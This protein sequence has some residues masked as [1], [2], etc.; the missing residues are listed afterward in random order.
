MIKQTSQSGFSLFSLILTIGVIAVLA[1]SVLVVVNPAKRI[2]QS[3]DARRWADVTAIAKAVEA[4]EIDNHQIPSDFSTTT[5]SAGEKFV[6]CSSSGFRTCDGQTEICLVVDD[7]DFLGVYLPDIPIDP[8]KSNS[9]DSGYYIT[10]QGDSTMVFGA[11]DSYDS[12]E[13]TLVAKATL[14]D[15]IAVCGDG[16]VDGDEV[17]DDGDT[18]TE[19]CGDGVLDTAGET[20]CNADCS[21]TYYSIE[22]CEFYNWTNDCEIIK[23]GW[24]TE[25][26][27]PPEASWCSSICRT[28]T[29]Y[30]I[31]L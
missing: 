21:D 18:Y 2:G 8:D 28:Q 11:C 15:V 25:A 16:D 5:L 24:V 23:A 14:P 29:G 12:T 31:G 1:A 26:D 9:V 22:T 7:D 3:K 10:R 20:F 30:C 4:Y 13:I 19:Q 6:L 17:C 27:L